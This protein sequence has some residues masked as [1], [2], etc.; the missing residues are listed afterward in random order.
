MQFLSSLPY[1]GRPICR[2]L[3]VTRQVIKL[4]SSSIASGDGLALDVIAGLVSQ[5][6]T[7]QRAGHEIILVTSGAAR[8]GWRLLSFEGPTAG[9]APALRALVESVR[10]LI[11][12]AADLGQ[13][14]GM[15]SGAGG[16][17]SA[18]ITPL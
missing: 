9:A 14:P 13:P 6:A 15:V 7:A 16:A 18:A 4:G 5:I 8:L 12:E 11:P 3:P 17:A 1:P 10:S 2:E